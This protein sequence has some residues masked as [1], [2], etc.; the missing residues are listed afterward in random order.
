MVKDPDGNLLSLSH[1]RRSRSYTR[2]VEDDAKGEAPAASQAAHPVA[3]VDAIG[4]ARPLHGPFAHREDDA[5]A[6]A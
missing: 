6:L 4:S 3:H 2:V 5:V 1:T